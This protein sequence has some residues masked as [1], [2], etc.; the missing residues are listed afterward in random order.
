MTSYAA[1]RTDEERAIAEI[2]QKALGIDRVGVHDNF[3]ELGGDSLIGLQ[4]VYA[5]QNR[6]ALAGRTLNLYEHSTVAAAA[7]F[8]TA[9]G[10]TS[11]DEGDEPAGPAEPQADPFALRSSRGE[12]RR[13]RRGS[14]KR[15]NR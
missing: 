5:V 4:V 11:G 9:G 7:R 14:S 13:E 1:P 10:T 3:L 2:W 6:F 8:V 12:Q 15:T